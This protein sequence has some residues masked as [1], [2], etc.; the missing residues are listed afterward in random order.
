MFFI[1]EHTLTGAG[2]ARVVSDHKFDFCEKCF[3]LKRIGGSRPILFLSM[4]HMWPQN[5]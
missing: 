5:G 4:I 3:E 1:R 2:G